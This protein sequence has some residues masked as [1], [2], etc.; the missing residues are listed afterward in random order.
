MDSDRT[1]PTR[2]S[3]DLEPGSPVTSSSSNFRRRIEFSEECE[4]TGDLVYHRDGVLVQARRQDRLHSGALEVVETRGQGVFITW[5]RDTGA[6]ETETSG[7]G[8]VIIN[9]QV[10]ARVVQ[11]YQLYHVSPC[12]PGTRGDV[13]GLAPERGLGGHLGQQ[14]LPGARHAHIQGQVLPQVRS[15][16]ESRR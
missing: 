2:H 4:V 3:P 5:E 12:V 11:L 15:G 7:Q 14:Q 16:P 10:R 1:T 13:C 8:R 6:G 9:D